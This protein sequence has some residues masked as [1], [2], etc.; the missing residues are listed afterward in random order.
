MVQWRDVISFW[1]DELK[2]EDWFKKNPELDQTIKD[3]FLSVHQEA[4]LGELEHWRASPL[5]RL[6]EV[7]VL[8]Q[9]SRNIYRDQ[10]ESFQSDTLALV[11]AQEAIRQKADQNIERKKQT[12]FYMPFMHSESMVIHRQAL[13][14]F[15]QPGFEYNLEFEKK[16]M[17]IIE[18][19][20]RYPH[21]NEILGRKSTAEEIEFLKQPDSSF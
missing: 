7:I 10:P 17:A 19:F 8:D 18:R 3:K 20:G 2:P 16:H 11:L 13:M 5:G 21:R 6:A 4:V 1:F 15:D 14:L 12:F 9:F